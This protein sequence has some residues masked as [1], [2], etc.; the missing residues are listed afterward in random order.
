MKLYMVESCSHTGVPVEV[1]PT[2][3]HTG[4]PVEVWPTLS[5]TGVPVEVWPT[6]PDITKVTIAEKISR[7]HQAILKK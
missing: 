6:L 3:S 2:L 4:V 7:G 5:H 1:W